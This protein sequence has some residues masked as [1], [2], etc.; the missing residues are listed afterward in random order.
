MID[1]IW[2]LLQFD[3][4]F[5]I[6]DEG[7]IVAI[8][9]LLRVSPTCNY[10]FH[11]QGM[12]WNG[13]RFFHIPYWQFSSIPFPFHTKNLPFHTKIFFHIPFHTKIFFHIPFH[14]EEILD[15]KQ[16]NVYFVALHLSALQCCEQLLV[17]VRQQY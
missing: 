4:V 11:R 10:G 9:R 14:T 15:W 6:D 2:A 1:K 13:R 8:V 16:C 3:Y 7:L 17:K 12:V 5:L